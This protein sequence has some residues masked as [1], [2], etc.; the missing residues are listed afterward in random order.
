[1][2]LFNW[3]LAGFET[4]YSKYYYMPHL[5]HCEDGVD[6]DG[7]FH[8]TLHECGRASCICAF[9]DELITYSRLFFKEDLMFK[10]RVDGI[11]AKLNPKA[12]STF[13]IMGAAFGYLMNELSAKKMNVW[14]CDN[15]PYIHFNTDTEADFVI[16]NINV[17]S[18][19]F[20]TDVETATGV[21]KFD[22]VITEDLLTSYDNDGTETIDEILFNAQSILKAGKPL[23]NIINIV[24]PNCASPFTTKTLVEWKN[25]NS[26]MTWLNDRGK[27]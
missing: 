17:L 2:K 25:V 12:G 16:H 4:A 6:D 18:S 11:I 5:S 24:T 8:D 15:S 20:A 14:G 22:Y 3:D 26:N 21:S 27:E 1:M 19:T 9:E 10:D 7:H 23:E 13:F